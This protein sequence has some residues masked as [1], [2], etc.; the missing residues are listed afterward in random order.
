MEHNYLNTLT[1]ELEMKKTLNLFLVACMA[2]SLAVVVGCKEKGPAE[3]MGEKIDKAAKQTGDD[4]KDTADKA[5][6]AADD[7]AK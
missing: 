5:K 2:L 6:K 4:A 3:K 1:K 7:A